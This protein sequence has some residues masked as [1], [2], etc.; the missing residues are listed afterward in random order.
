MDQ[1]TNA[2][3]SNALRAARILRRMTQRDLAKLTGFSSAAH[4]RSETRL[5]T[6]GGKALAM[7]TARALGFADLDAMVKECGS[8]E[9][10]SKASPRMRRGHPTDESRPTDNFGPKLDALTVAIGK[11]ADQVHVIYSQLV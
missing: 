2:T 10:P 1:P 8:K 4:S 3:I 7:A 9:I 11:L 6:R 5:Q